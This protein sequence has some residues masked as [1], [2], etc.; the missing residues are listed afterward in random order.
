MLNGKAT[1]HSELLQKNTTV[2]DRFVAEHTTHMTC[3]FAQQVQSGCWSVPI[4]QK[5]KPNLTEGRCFQRESSVLPTRHTCWNMY[6]RT[7]LMSKGASIATIIECFYKIPLSL[8]SISLNKTIYY[9][10]DEKFRY[11]NIHNHP[12]T[13][14]MPMLTK[15]DLLREAIQNVKTWTN[16]DVLNQ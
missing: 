10:Y 9:L 15:V 12:S 1:S 4:Y 11:F 16:S 2:W 14:N 13:Q 6:M 3:T 8:V 5:A 7:P